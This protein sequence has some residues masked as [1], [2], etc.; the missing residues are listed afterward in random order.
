MAALS[1]V[2]ADADALPLWIIGIR[3]VANQGRLNDAGELC[4]RALELHPLSAELQ[5]LHATLLTEA[6][7]FSDAVAASR[8]AIY[9]DRNFIMG[10]LLLG[11]TLTRVGDPEGARI[12]FTNA[13]H[14][15]ENADADA[16]VTAADGVTVTRLRQVAGLR[17]RTLAPDAT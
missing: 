11:D 2:T 15:L 17:L 13:L 8:R 16:V 6:G 9:L 12:A 1:E 10:H 7:W 14:L 3:S 5:Y 4:A